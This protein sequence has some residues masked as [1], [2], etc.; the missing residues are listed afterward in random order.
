MFQKESCDKSQSMSTICCKV[1]FEMCPYSI[2]VRGLCRTCT[3]LST[4][5]LLSTDR[6]S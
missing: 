3:D 2:S 6:R 1:I 4:L 5:D